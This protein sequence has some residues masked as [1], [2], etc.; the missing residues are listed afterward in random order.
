MASSRRKV[1]LELL[2]AWCRC[3]RKW[4]EPCGQTQSHGR[5]L[6]REVPRSAGLTEAIQGDFCEVPAPEMLRSTLDRTMVPCHG[7]YVY[8]DLAKEIAETPGFEKRLRDQVLAGDWGPQYEKHPVV[9]APSW[10]IRGSPRAQR[11]WRAIPTQG[12][13]HWLLVCQL[14]HGSAA[15]VL[16]DAEEEHVAVWL[17]R[18]V[19]PRGHTPVGWSIRSTRAATRDNG[20]PR[21]SD[22]QRVLAGSDLG[23]VGAMIMVKGDWAEFAVTFGYHTN[24]CFL[25]DASGGPDGTWRD[26]EG[27]SMFS[28]PWHAKT[29]EMHDAAWRTDHDDRLSRSRY[30][31]ESASGVVPDVLEFPQV[32]RVRS[33]F[34]SR[35]CSHYVVQSL[36]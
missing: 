15:L 36:R 23:F 4:S 27:I 14:A 20:T 33:K 30:R 11:R 8:E 17:Q 25:C 34:S 13:G 22:P 35:W 5:R 24:P 3:P 2:G 1:Y 18:L 26:T 19:Q 32:G 6:Q 31:Q 10:A 28:S 9:Q 29:F 21:A 7:A 16:H 12:F